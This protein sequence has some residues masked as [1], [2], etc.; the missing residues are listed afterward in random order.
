MHA[1]VCAG[2]SESV[3]TVRGTCYEKIRTGE[4]RARAGMANIS[5]KIHKQD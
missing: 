1:F 2:M 4:I 5:E 3:E